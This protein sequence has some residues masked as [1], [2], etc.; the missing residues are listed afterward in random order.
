MQ[1]KKVVLDKG[2]VE[3]IDY[4]GDDLRVVNSAKI[5]RRKESKILSNRDEILIQNLANW[6]HWTPFSH[7]SIQLKIK[8]PIFI[9][10]QYFKSQVGFTRNEESRRSITDTP[11]F[12][13]P[14]KLNCELIEEKH[15]LY[16][17]IAMSYEKN[18]NLY[19]KLLS[20]GVIPEQARIVL[21]QSMYTTFIE[22]GN[23]WS[24]SRMYN[25]RIKEDAQ[26]EVRNYAKII[27]DIIS[28]IA[29][30]SWEA[31]TKNKK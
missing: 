23:L 25:L 11:D 5:S 8:M 4:M 14:N 10:R 20:N 12:Y 1:R 28:E 26:W 22:T 3:L 16:N 19:N 9:A 18:I 31:L 6:G 13:L 15:F 27:G 24:Y 2:F 21:P 30:I 17:D 7:V 29:P